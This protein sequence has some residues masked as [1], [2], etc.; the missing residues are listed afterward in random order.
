M[1]MKFDSLQLRREDNLERYLSNDKISEYVRE[2][3]FEAILQKMKKIEELK[4]IKI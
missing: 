3:R 4:Y 2:K 1:L